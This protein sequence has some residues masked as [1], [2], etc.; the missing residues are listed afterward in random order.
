MAVL[1]INSQSGDA[2]RDLA[3]WRRHLQ[4]VGLTGFDEVDFLDDDWR[5]TVRKNQLVLA[6]GGDGTVSAVVG[7]CVE[8]EAVLAV[9]P[10][11][12]A[13]DFARSL[14][15]E[16]DAETACRI[17]ADG[18]ERSVDVGVV[19]GRVFINVV[20]IGLGAAASAHVDAEAKSDWG[21]LSYVRSLVEKLD[22]DSGFSATIHV[23][24]ERLDGAWLEIG[25]ANGS[26]YGGGHRVPATTPD[27]GVLNFFGVRPDHAAYLAVEYAKVRLLG[28]EEG[29]SELLEHRRFRHCRIETES[30]QPVT[31]DG[32]DV[33][34]TP[35]EI[36]IRAGALRVR[37]P[38]QG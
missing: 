3:F 1:V 4:A 30:P 29:S 2:Q 27:D 35:V 31:A 10:S 28:P 33:G 14:G 17:A 16:A 38:N 25:V 13:N 19:N 18:P 21:D 9:L 5:D 36:E 37:A 12:T 15:V 22:D 24:D 32:E 26:F 23:D 34:Y 7:A 11:G 8:A 6:A 20:H